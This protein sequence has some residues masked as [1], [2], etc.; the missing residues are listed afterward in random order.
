MTVSQWSQIAIDPP[1]TDWTVRLRPPPVSKWNEIALPAPVTQWSILSD[2]IPQRW[3]CPHLLAN[4]Q[5]FYTATITATISAP[6]LINSQTFYSP[7]TTQGIAPGL[8]TNAQTF[9]ESRMVAT[10]TAPLLTNVQTF[11]EPIVLPLL[12]PSLFTNVQ[13]F[14]APRTTQYLAPALFTNS[15][16]FYAA[17]ISSPPVRTYIGTT[18]NAADQTIYTFTNHA[19]GAAAADR[20][21]LVTIMAHNTFSRKV[22][23]VTIGGNAA[24][25]ATNS[26]ISVGRFCT[27]AWLVVPTGTT[28][29]IV[30][31]FSGGASNCTISVNTITGLLSTTPI[32]ENTVQADPAN[33]NATTSTDCV[34]LAGAAMAAIGPSFTW[35][36]VTEDYYSSPESGSSVSSA[37]ASGVPA[38][39]LSVTADSDGYA[40]RLSAIVFR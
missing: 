26:N 38:A 28:A 18:P 25:L 32:Y 4:S 15:Q 35:T 3:L 11:Y 31:T 21:V 14:H 20:L 33:L 17:T 34:V 6:L 10:I 19:I 22:S 9:F 5:A 24:T 7:V 12:A 40:T 2:F 39:S 27:F 1:V 36:N 23:S 37:G 16:T 29:T 8:V 13:T 30:V